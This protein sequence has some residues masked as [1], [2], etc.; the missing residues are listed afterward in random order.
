[1]LYK[2]KRVK[3]SLNSK[4]IIINNIMRIQQKALKTKNSII[5]KSETNSISVVKNCIIIN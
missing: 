1:M 2:K 5:K 4:F 3:L